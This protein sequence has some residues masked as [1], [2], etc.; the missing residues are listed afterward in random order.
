MTNAA[1]A[2]DGG[3]LVSFIGG[4]TQFV[5]LIKVGSQLIALSLRVM[6]LLQVPSS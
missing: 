3:G 1:M 5:V 2:S 4:T 6:S